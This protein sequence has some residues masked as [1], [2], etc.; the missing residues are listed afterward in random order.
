[1]F[2]KNIDRVKHFWVE[3]FNNLKTVTQKNFR[4]KAWMLD[5]LITS[6][7]RLSV[8]INQVEILHRH[9]VLEITIIVHVYLF[10]MIFFK[11]SFALYEL[12]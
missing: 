9:F 4:A 12:N 3:K 6:Q 7:T 5:L 11:F 8:K 2:V 1:M 10:K